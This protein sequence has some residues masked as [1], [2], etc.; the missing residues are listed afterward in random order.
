MKIDYNKHMYTW[1]V[2]KGC[3][4]EWVDGRTKYKG[5]VKRV[6]SAPSMYGTDP[7]QVVVET[8]DKTIITVDVDKIRVL[9]KETK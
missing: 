7:Y 8:A 6:I 3:R 1:R 9:K 4:V 5:V 2:Q